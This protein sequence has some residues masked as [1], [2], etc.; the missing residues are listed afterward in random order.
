MAYV[1]FILSQG[2]NG[3]SSIKPRMVLNGILRISSDAN[4][5]ALLELDSTF[6]KVR[7]SACSGKK[8]RTTGESRGGKNIKIPVL[9][10]ER[11]SD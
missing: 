10:N 2:I 1:K 9:L 11:I 4:N 5:S 3:R 6:C 8:I 7:Q